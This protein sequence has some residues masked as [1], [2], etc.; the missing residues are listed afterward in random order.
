MGRPW[1]HPMQ[2]VVR[3]VYSNGASSL[4]VVPWQQPTTGLRVTTKFLQSDHL[5]AEPYTGVA[6]RAPKQGRRARFEKRFAAKGPADT[7]ANADAEPNE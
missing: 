5:T 4:M 3:V 1:L 7:D 2:H 6:S